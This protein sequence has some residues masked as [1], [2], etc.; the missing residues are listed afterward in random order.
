MTVSTVTPVKL[1][2]KCGKRKTERDKTKCYACARPHMDS[3]NPL[4]TA[5]KRVQ[6][7]KR[8]R[9]CPCC[10]KF[11][12]H[13]CQLNRDHIDGNNR[14]HDES[15]LQDICVYCHNLKTY[16]QSYPKNWLAYC[17]KMHL[18]HQS[19]FTYPYARL[20]QDKIEEIFALPV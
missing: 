1:C 3:S 19:E 4:A 14:N 2:A 6:R 5:R 11:P 8:L 15:N 12:V 16:I 10:G 17:K 9:P 18:P 13:V 7:Q 20:L